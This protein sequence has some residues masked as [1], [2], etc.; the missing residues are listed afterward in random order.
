MKREKESLDQQL[1]SMGI[2]PPTG[3]SYIPTPAEMRSG[4]NLVMATH[5]SSSTGGRDRALTTDS[6]GGELSEA[7]SISTNP[8]QKG[9][10][11]STLRIRSSS[12]S[13]NTESGRLSTQV[14]DFDI[15]KQG[16]GW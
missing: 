13:E 8:G 7:M 5:D 3:P 11:P 16:K 10:Q 2:N 14:P 15:N 9:K 12:E 6:Y 1:Q 4:T